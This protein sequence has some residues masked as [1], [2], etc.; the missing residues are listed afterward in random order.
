MIVST[1]NRSLIKV[2]YFSSLNFG[3]NSSFKFVSNNAA[4]IALGDS[5]LPLDG[6]KPEL[7]SHQIIENEKVHSAHNYHP[8][9]VVLSSAKGIYVKDVEGRTYIDFLSAYSAVNQ[10]HSHPKIL[11]TLKQQSSKLT[12]C[13]RAFY[14]DVFGKFA[15]FLTSVFKYDKVLPMNTGAEAVETALKVAR[16]WGYMSK[17]IEKDKAIILG[18]SGN[19]HGRTLGVIS[20][21][22]STSATKDFGPFVP[23]LGP[24]AS[25]GVD[26]IPFDDLKALKAAIK[27]DGPRIAGF[28]VEPIQGEAGVHVPSKSY[29]KKAYELCKENNIL[30][31]AD[32]VQTGLGRTGTMLA[33]EQSKIRPDIVILGKALSGG[34]YPVSAVL[35]DD[36]I[37]GLIKPDEH[38]STYGGNPLACAVAITALDVIIKEKLA[39]KAHRLGKRLRKKI[40]EIQHTAIMEVRGRGLLNAIVIDPSKIDGKTAWDLCL[41]MKKNGLLAKPTHN[42]IIRFAPPLTIKKEEIDRSVEIIKA[43]LQ[44]LESVNVN[45]IA[46]RT[47]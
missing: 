14:N 32:E 35:A 34:V 43:S 38:G 39:K 15:E 45:D 29:L 12:L 44:E 16:K 27:A 33:V 23:G 11:K 36:P 6:V 17:G 9:P 37:L 24:K 5:S 21:S 3:L 46:D 20:M 25:T 10:G 30:F 2:K 4:S 31:I 42:N 22:T 8:L 40:E 28:I 47:L 7:T 19:F 41:I 13:S 26:C 18:C 1:I